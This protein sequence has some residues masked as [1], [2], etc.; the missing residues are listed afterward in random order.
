MCA[1]KVWPDMI[2]LLHERK[3]RNVALVGSFVLVADLLHAGEAWD[4][5]MDGCSFYST[6][7]RR[8]LFNCRLSTSLWLLGRLVKM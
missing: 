2:S 4:D 1:E 6:T 8:L 3:L 7:L 5:P